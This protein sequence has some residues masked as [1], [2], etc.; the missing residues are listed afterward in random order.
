MNLE[1]MLDR[2]D[3]KA[4]RID[5]R[6]LKKLF[7]EIVS[8]RLLFWSGSALM[9]LATAMVLLEPALFGWIVDDV[10]VP[11]RS[12][13]LP[14]A[15]LAFGAVVLFRVVFMIAQA[16][17]FEWLGQK[18]MHELR[19]RL[20]AHLQTLPLEIF[21]RTPVGRL[22]TRLTND[23]SS[24]SEMFASGF[25][26]M[27]GNLLTV[28]GIMIWL[29]IL[30][31]RLALVACSLMPALVVA[32]IYFS[33]KLQVAYRSA[34]SRISALNAFTAENI[35]GSRIVTLFN[36]GDTQ[37][38][39]YQRV[40]EWYSEAQIGSVRVYAYFQPAIT[41]TSGIALAMV[42]YYG[43][44]LS[45]SQEIKIGA[46]VAFMS[47]TLNM[48]QPLR[49]MADKW[50]IF[51]SGITS[52]ERIFAILDWQVEQPAS[53]ALGLNGIDGAAV[54][55]TIQNRPTR[56]HLVFENVFF[57]YPTGKAPVGEP[58]WVLKDFNLEILPGQS[59]GI[60]GHTGAGKTTI[61]SLLMR[62]YEPQRG[63]ILL[64]GIDLREYSLPEL[65][66]RIGIVQQDV[67]L[68][69]GSIEENITLWKEPQGQLSPLVRG[70]ISDA[71]IHVGKDGLDERGGNLSAGQRQILAFARAAAHKPGVWI[72]DEAT[73]N[74]DSSTEKQVETAFAQESKGKT[75]ILIAHR[76]AT[77]KTADLII[78]MHQGAILEKGSHSELIAQGGLYS[79]MFRYQS[80]VVEPAPSAENAGIQN[81]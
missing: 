65:R 79:R 23:V 78:V 42:L 12:D 27:L 2:E 16:Y 24:L 49:D 14:M 5:P 26:S 47:Y 37:F 3:L 21:D 69:S 43:G 81:V 32:S 20:L 50:N 76:L 36:R 52:A 1:S 33:R 56:G 17:L 72:L 40:N 19:L 68:F 61:I 54:R 6:T 8:H 18:L 10:I 71:R 73:A 31:W 77:V 55:A 59:V 35:L 15:A 57:A 80:A 64:D 41:L 39:R 74:V 13:V 30:D 28:I 34:R 60:V 70:L 45:L 62:F 51:L 46:W 11:K 48:F 9:L 67:F 44:V 38:E 53:V 22:V 4:Q 58:R 7:A 66:S 63:R 29:F 25:V 75:S